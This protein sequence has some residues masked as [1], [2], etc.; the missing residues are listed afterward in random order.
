MNSSYILD[1]P[2]ASSF[3]NTTENEYLRGMMILES[4]QTTNNYLNEGII[5][6]EINDHDLNMNIS[7][8]II[9]SPPPSNISR[10]NFQ[11][12]LISYAVL[13]S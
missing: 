9:P 2:S 4:N 5:V 11:L 1:S 12:I 6:S 7:D 3:M 10:V 13:L 8:F